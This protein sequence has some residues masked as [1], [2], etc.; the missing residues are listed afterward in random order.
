[1]GECAGGPDCPY[2]PVGSTLGTQFVVPLPNG[3]TRFF[4]VTAYD[5]SGNESKLSKDDV[6]DTPRPAG[7]GLALA[8]YVASPATS[9]YDFSAYSVVPFDSPNVDIFFSYDGATYQ[10]FAPFADTRIED[11][12]YTSSLDDIDYAPPQPYGW[13][14]NGSVKLFERHSY[15]VW[16]DNGVGGNYA[17]FRVVGLSASPARVVLDWAYQTDVGNGELRASHGKREG[18]RARRPVAWLR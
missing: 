13:P 14:D 9:G 1:M 11:A 6:F 17:K 2:D 3:T 10:M 16:I 8:D 5:R 15:V 7:S 12:G 4:A 18:A